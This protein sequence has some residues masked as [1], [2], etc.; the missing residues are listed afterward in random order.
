MIKILHSKA[1]CVAVIGAGGFAREVLTYLIK[2]VGTA[3]F[4]SDEFWTDNLRINVGDDKH[5]I[6]KP[7][8]LSQLDPTVFDVIVAIGDPKARAKIVAE[9][10]EFNYVSVIASDSVYGGNRIGK[11]CIICPGTIITTNVTLGDH[12]QLNLQT[13]VGHDTILGDF[14]TTAP[15]AK[16]S[17]N[18]K[19]GNRVY[20]G[21][22][23]SIKE[24]IDI[25]DDAV[26][27]LN[28]GVVKNIVEAGTY[29]GTP[30]KKIV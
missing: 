8:K 18:C 9:H 27:G 23:A 12:V 20:I 17:G 13:T 28:A 22:N 29:V 3:P 24:K 26:I 11:G 7:K 30:A 14:V 1:P 2:E 10:P 21:T 16:I 25:C 15:G 19:I 4:V 5:L 6:F